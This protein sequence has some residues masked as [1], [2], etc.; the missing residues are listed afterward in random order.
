VGAANPGHGWAAPQSIAD[1][2][3]PIR[4]GIRKSEI[5]AALV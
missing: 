5:R 1:E 2:L 4:I 3:R